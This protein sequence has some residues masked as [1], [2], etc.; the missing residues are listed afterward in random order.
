M[1]EFLFEVHSDGPVAAGIDGEAVKLEPPV[2]FRSRPRA[3]RVRIAPQHPGASP[4]AAIPP[5]PQGAIRALF[6][7]AIHGAS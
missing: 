5:H 7:I 3:L 2:R 1:V 6:H 4:S